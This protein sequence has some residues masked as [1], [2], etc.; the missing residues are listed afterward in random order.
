[1]LKLLLLLLRLLLLLLR[2]G[3]RQQRSLVPHRNGALRQGAR[4]EGG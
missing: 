3:P 2:R 1:M 4:V